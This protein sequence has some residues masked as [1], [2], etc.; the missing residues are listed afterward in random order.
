MNVLAFEKKYLRL[1][2]INCDRIF[3]IKICLSNVNFYKNTLTYGFLLT[4]CKSVTKYDSLIV[5]PVSKNGDGVD[6]DD[7]VLLMMMLMSLIHTW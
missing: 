1:W 4:N 6:D 7:D 2:K 3:I 5:T